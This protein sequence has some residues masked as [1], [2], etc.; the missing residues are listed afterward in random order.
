MSEYSNK[1]QVVKKSTSTSAE[2]QDFYASCEVRGQEGQGR[3]REERERE[4][5]RGREE[6]EEIG[7]LPL[8]VAV[9]I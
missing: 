3:E 2:G 1:V 8:Q 5:E 4:R 9:K 6:M 7:L